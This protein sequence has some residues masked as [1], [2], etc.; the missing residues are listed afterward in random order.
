VA[1]TDDMPIH[2]TDVLETLWGDTETEIRRHGR[3]FRFLD[4]RMFVNELIVP[5]LQAIEREIEMAAATDSAVAAWVRDIDIIYSF[6]SRDIAGSPTR[7][8]HSW[9][10]A[11]DFVPKS[12]DGRHVY[13]RWS[14]VFDR[15]GWDRIPLTER[16]SPPE[17]VVG[18]FQSHGFIW[19]GKWAHF[20]VIHFEY[21]PEI[22]LYNRLV[23]GSAD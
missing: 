1:A 6:V 15:E 22:I 12:Y 7:S 2:C 3:S 23:E 16:W 10:M 21:R 18:I 17:A 11:I 20:D 14:R 13:W 9:G 8:H 19:G 4:H 5:P